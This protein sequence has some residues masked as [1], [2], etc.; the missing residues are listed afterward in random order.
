MGFQTFC[1][2]ASLGAIGMPQTL[3]T[4]ER[5]VDVPD[6]IL[7]VLDTNRDPNEVVTDPGLLEFLVAELPVRCRGGMA[8]QRFRVADVHQAQDHLQPVDERAARLLAAFYTEGEDSGRSPARQLL[9]KCVI[10]ASG[11]A[12]IIDPIHLRMGLQVFSNLERVLAVPL[13]SQPEGLQSLKQQEGAVGSQG[14]TGIA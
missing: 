2:A 1:P 10:L 7:D 14:R 12:R 6:D 5:L 8:S 13:H 3:D 11:K 9:G 4:R